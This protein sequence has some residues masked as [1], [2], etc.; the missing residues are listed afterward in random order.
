MIRQLAKGLLA[1]MTLLL[2]ARFTFAAP[3]VLGLPIQCQIGVDCYIQN[4]ID[5]NSGPGHRDYACGS[6]SYDGHNGT[7]FA[8]A[9]LAVMN[10]GVN[11]LAASAGTVLTVRD[12]EPDISINQRGHKSL[13]GK[14]AGNSVRIRHN[15][16]WET[17]YSHMK[18]GSIAV[19]AGQTVKSGTVL[20][21][22]G[23]SG[24][25]EFPHMHFTVR[26][27]GLLVDPFAPEQQDCGVSKQTLWKPSLEK[28]MIYRPTGLVNAGFAPELPKREQVDAGNYSATTLAPDSSSIA[29]W[30][31][32]FGLQKEDVIE[33][34]LSDTYGQVLSD[35]RKTVDSNKAMAFAFIGERRTNEVWP[36]GT[37]TGRVIL[38]RGSH[39]V[40]NESRAATVP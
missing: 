27:L 23:L 14:D 16:G 1:T 9:N 29:F 22:V 15:D 19:R 33:L 40:I 28:T 11:V 12:G 4:F 13:A 21:Q 30:M 35:S 26:H 34:I 32:M 37:Y 6:L 25:T 31:I 7:D 5:H 10:A 39:V 38:Y 24:Y 36:T 8:I 3:P 2:T 20:G 18:H 17:Q